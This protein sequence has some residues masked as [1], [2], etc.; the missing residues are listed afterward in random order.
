MLQTDGT[1]QIKEAKCLSSTLIRKS[2]ANVSVSLDGL[3]H[4]NAA[5]ASEC[6]L[7]IYDC[8]LKNE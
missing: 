6:N 8:F 3:Q 5:S 2:H 7:T 4:I 1:D